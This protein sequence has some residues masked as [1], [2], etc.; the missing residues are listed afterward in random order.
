[1]LKCENCCYFAVTTSDEWGGIEHCC[2]HEWG[3]GDWETAPC[4][5]DDE[6]YGDDGDEYEE[7]YEITAADLHDYMYGI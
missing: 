6:Y 5:Y 4:D 1:M 7:D 3:H 2:F